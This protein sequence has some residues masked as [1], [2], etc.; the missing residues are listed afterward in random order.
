MIDLIVS[1]KLSC[2]EVRAFLLL[3]INDV[4]VHLFLS[5]TSP[6]WRFWLHPVV[7]IKTAAPGFW[8]E[9]ENKIDFFHKRSQSRGLCVYL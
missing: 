9:W 2:R 3:L 5:A 1:I 7:R 4:H 6:A 8:W